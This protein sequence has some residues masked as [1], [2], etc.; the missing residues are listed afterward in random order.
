MASPD[1]IAAQILSSKSLSVSPV[2]LN[3]FLSS[4]S[5]QR[6]VPPSALAKTAIFRL[7]ASNITESLSKHRSCI[8]PVDAYDPMVQERRLQGAIP[9]QVLDIEDIGTSLWSQIEAIE[10]VERGEAIRGR[11]IVRTIA[12]DEDPEATETNGANSGP[13]AAANASGNS[14]SGPHRLILQDAEGTVVAG[15]EMQRVDGISVEKLAIGAKLLLRD[16]TVARGMVLLN[17]GSVTVLGGKIEAM[18]TPWRQ[19][20]KARLLE[21]TAGLE[22]E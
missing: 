6:N 9:V 1:Q 13:V 18:D 21:K 4:A 14:G 22:G 15:V 5:A 10:R 8:L 20:R 19:G 7:L 16:P 2:W 12:V 11:E 17:P 3:A